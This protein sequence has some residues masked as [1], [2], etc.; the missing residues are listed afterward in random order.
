MIVSCA[1]LDDFWNWL[2]NSQLASTLIIL[3]FGTFIFESW[4]K[5]KEACREMIWWLIGHIE[6]YAEMANSYWTAHPSKDAAQLVRASRLKNEYS[7]L[8]TSIDN[9][10]GV[11]KKT[12]SEVRI[13]ITELYEAATGGEFETSKKTSQKDLIKTLALIAKHS[14]ILRRMLRTAVA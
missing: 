11:S 14:A 1:I 4:L 8:L 10:N 7:V 5:R 2:N 6:E 9:V 13:S 12:K 3:I